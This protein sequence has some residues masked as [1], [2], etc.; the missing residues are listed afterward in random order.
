MNVSVRI[1]IGNSSNWLATD[2]LE[3]K[4][5]ILNL[6]FFSNSETFVSEKI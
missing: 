1:E 4:N 6:F 2:E 5:R 3:M